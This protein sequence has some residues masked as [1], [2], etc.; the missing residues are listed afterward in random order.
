[1]PTATKSKK[2]KKQQKTDITVQSDDNIVK[3]NDNDDAADDAQAYLDGLTDTADKQ[4]EKGDDSCL[5]C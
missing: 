1:M 3:D 2:S 4:A 5:F